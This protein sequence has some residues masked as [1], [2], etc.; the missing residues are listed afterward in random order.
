MKA[1]LLSKRRLDE[2]SSKLR[3]LRHQLNIHIQL[4]IGRDIANVEDENAT[5]FETCYVKY[6]FKTKV[7]NVCMFLIH[8]YL[9]F[10]IPTVNP[11]PY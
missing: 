5:Y 7:K 9:L 8:F 4:H 11:R 6:V 2:V 1:I 10:A 3:V